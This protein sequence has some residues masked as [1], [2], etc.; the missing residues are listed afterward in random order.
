MKKLKRIP[1][2]IATMI[3]GT[4]FVMSSCNKEEAIA[5]G[6]GDEKLAPGN[7]TSLVDCGCLV[8]PADTIYPA[9]IE[10]LKFMREEEKLARDVYTTL[11]TQYSVPIFKNIAKSEQFHMDQVLCLLQ[12]YNIEDPASPEVGVFFNMNL[13]D[14]YDNLVEQGAVSLND[15]LTVGATIEDLDIND[16]QNLVIQTSNEAIITVFGHLTCGS[17]NHIRSF[18]AI[19]NARGGTYVPQYISQDDYQAIIADEHEFCGCVS[20]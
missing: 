12:H 14:M 18:S 11:S 4:A 9:E 10:I 19:L 6:T 20:Q 5:S 16:L 15:A 17:R 3:I 8:N 13:Q 1:L 7:E 2:V